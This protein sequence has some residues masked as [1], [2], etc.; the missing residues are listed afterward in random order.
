MKRLTLRLDDKTH[1]RLRAKA[2]KENKS[3]NTVILEELNKK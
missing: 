3:L 1:K 2:Y